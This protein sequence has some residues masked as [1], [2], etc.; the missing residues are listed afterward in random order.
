MVAYDS[1]EIGPV[2][3]DI[4]TKNNMTIEYVAN[5]TGLSVST[6]CQIEQGGRRM[7]RKTLYLLMNVYGEDATTLLA[8][9][10]KFAKDIETIDQRL[11][12]LP[13]AERDYLE[14]LF[15]AMIEASLEGEGKYV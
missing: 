13:L 12:G 8:I 5:Q 4:R 7:S 1:Y 14:K 11:Q 10:N 15:C 6:I 2:L 3:R 9:G